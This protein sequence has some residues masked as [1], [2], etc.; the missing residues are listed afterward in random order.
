L[1]LTC[2]RSVDFPSIPVASIH[3]TDCHNITEILL[4]VVLN[5]ITH[6]HIEINE[7]TDKCW[8]VVCK[9]V[10]S[11]EYKVR[12]R[13]MVFNTIFNKISVISWRSVYLVEETGV[14]GENHWPAASHWQALSHNL[15]SSTPRLS[16]IRTHNVS[17]DRHWLHR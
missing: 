16:K 14:P 5:T 8:R 15:V 9:F 12:V 6:K 17:G 1:P 11:N 10:T 2:S 4:K 13:V 7:T 3:K